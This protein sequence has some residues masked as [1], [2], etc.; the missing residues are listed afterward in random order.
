VFV[1]DESGAADVVIDAHTLA[2]RSTI[3]LGGEA[4]NRTS[5]ELHTHTA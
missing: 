5:F 2:K 1:S 4:G 3:A